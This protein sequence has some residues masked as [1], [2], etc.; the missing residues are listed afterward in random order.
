MLQS[1][2]VAHYDLI[3]VWTA[4]VFEVVLLEDG[5]ILSRM[6]PGYLTLLLGRI[7]ILQPHIR[8]LG[9]VLN[10][11]LL[12]HI[13][14][15]L[16]HFPLHFLILNILKS[17]I[18]GGRHAPMATSQAGRLMRETA[19]FERLRSNFLAEARR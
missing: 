17:S 1:I 9:S 12:P 7:S 4:Q 6:K 2:E 15:I 5:L 13:R 16:H 10:L 8:S 11:L 3:L 19:Q 18:A 14:L